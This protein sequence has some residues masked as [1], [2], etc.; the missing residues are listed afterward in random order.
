MHR[1]LLVTRRLFDDG[2]HLAADEAA[3][4][5]A[6]HEFL[7]LVQAVD[8][9]EIASGEHTQSEFSRRGGKHWEIQSII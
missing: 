3:H 7:L 8:V 5:I 9:V 6:Q 4:G 2:E 1:K